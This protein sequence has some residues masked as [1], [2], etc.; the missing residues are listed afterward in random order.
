VGKLLEMPPREVCLVALIRHGWT[1]VNGCW[2]AN[3]TQNRDTGYVQVR[4]GNRLYVASRLAHVAWIGPIPDG[5]RV[6][7]TCDNPPCINPAHLFAGTMGD[8]M[9]DMWLKDRRPRGTRSSKFGMTE[10]RRVRKLRAAGLSW[11]Q[12]ADATGMSVGNCRLIVGLGGWPEGKG[13]RI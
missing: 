11:Q 13:R 7:H 6:L 4:I 9:D 2:I 1:E 12:V 10:A 8:N 3:G 5:E